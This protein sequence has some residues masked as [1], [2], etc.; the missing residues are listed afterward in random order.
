M[1]WPEESFEKGHLDSI[2]GTEN[3]RGD[4]E[5]LSISRIHSN[6]TPFFGGGMGEDLILTY[7]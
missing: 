4:T 2:T 7:L 5:K 6:E 1:W 3:V